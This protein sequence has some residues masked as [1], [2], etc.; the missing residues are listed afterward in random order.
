M[1]VDKVK[2]VVFKLPGFITKLMQLLS[3]KKQA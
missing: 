3:R 2:I 1:E